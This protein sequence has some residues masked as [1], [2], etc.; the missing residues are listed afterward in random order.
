MRRILVVEED[1]YLRKQVYWALKDIILPQ[2]LPS[3]LGTEKKK[4]SDFFSI[5]FSL[6]E[7]EKILI[8]NALREPYPS[9]R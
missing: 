8:E 4:M 1:K 6:H 7:L 9:L 2:R 5:N 3:D